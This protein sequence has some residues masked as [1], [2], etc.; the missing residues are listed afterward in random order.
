MFNILLLKAS[1]TI[2][3]SFFNLIQVVACERAAP[4]LISCLSTST[5]NPLILAKN[6]SGST[7]GSPSVLYLLYAPLNAPS[8]CI[9]HQF[10]SARSGSLL[11]IR[12]CLF[13]PFFTLHIFLF[14]SAILTSMHL[15]LDGGCC[16][17]GA[18]LMGS[19]GTLIARRQAPDSASCEGYLIYVSFHGPYLL[20]LETRVR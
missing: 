18:P 3:P 5:R 9:G 4:V 17:S 20:S 13:H 16:L 2:F 14:N 10:K 8:S 15:G 1:S 11:A 19:L 7:P 6:I 12:Q